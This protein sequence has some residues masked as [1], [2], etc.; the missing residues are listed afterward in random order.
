NA[1]TLPPIK[2]HTGFDPSRPI[3]GWYKEND[4]CN[5]HR[6]NGHSDSNCITFKNIVQGMLE[7]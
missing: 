1:I 2:P 6:V 5:Y 3:P 4:Y 7:S